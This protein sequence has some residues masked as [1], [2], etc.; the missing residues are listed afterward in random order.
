M[1]SF[2]YDGEARAAC[3]SSNLPLDP[4]L[5]AG[6]MRIELVQACA[7]RLGLPFAQK[8]ISLIT[9]YEAFN[10]IRKTNCP[11]PTRVLTSKK[12]C[13]QILELEMWKVVRRVSMAEA[14]GYATYFSVPKSDELA[15]AIFN[16]RTLSLA[17]VSPPPVN[18]PR[19]DDIFHGLAD[20]TFFVEA[21]FRHFFHQIRMARLI[22]LSMCIGLG[23]KTFCWRTL[24]MG[25]SFSPYIAQSISWV[26]ILRALEKSGLVQEINIEN[27]TSCPRF[28]SS[29]SFFTTVYYDNL[30]AGFTSA[31]KRDDF[32]HALKGICREWRI[33]FSG[34]GPRRYS[35]K[36]MGCNS[37][38]KKHLHYLGIEFAFGKRARDGQNQLCWRHDLEKIERWK[39]ARLTLNEPSS[40]RAV[41]QVLGCVIWDAMVRLIPLC[42]IEAELD[43]FR[44]VS[45]NAT[46]HGWDFPMTWP[47]DS[48]QLIN[49]RLDEITSNGWSSHLP[50]TNCLEIIAASDASDVGLGGVCWNA[51][52]LDTSFTI[53]EPIPAKLVGSHIYLREM[54]AALLTISKILKF[55]RNVHITLAIDNTAVMH[56][57]RNMYSRN[58]AGNEMIRRIHEILTLSNS[59]LTTIPIISIDNPADGPSRMRKVCTL[60]A[61]TCLIRIAEFYQGRAGAEIH[62]HKR[63]SF[64]GALRHD[65]PLDAKWTDLEEA[66]CFDDFEHSNDL[67][68]L[69]DPEVVIDSE[70]EVWNEVDDDDE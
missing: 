57:L 16:G 59:R 60:T 24:P 26:I 2:L 42:D 5:C 31:E 25:W 20:K 40:A 49:N 15:R 58:R 44:T 66:I 30:L 41:A 22:S 68:S 37:E 32:F 11:L 10:E 54:Y 56:A 69:E 43:V 12:W 61:A 63:P 23:R 53:C 39:K 21:D 65:E 38:A 62:A 27:L 6:K 70:P 34:D 47:N 8:A 17:F 7:E 67:A 36:D 14:R 50:M 52:Q 13:P 4:I 33:A 28:L 64:S 29:C 1:S 55:R 48:L 9:S 51:E 19:L 3:I 18:L 46:T 35:A 45:R